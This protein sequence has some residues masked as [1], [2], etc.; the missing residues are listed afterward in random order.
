MATVVEKLHVNM[1]GAIESRKHNI[2]RHMSLE[3]SIP[4][5]PPGTGL[6]PI[7]PSTISHVSQTGNQKT[8]PN[9]D[10]RFLQ[11][12]WVNGGF[13]F[14]YGSKWYD[15]VLNKASVQADK[16]PICWRATCVSVLSKSFTSCQRVIS[17]AARRFWA[18]G[19][20]EILGPTKARIF[21]GVACLMSFVS[22]H[23]PARKK[24]ISHDLSTIFGSTGRLYSSAGAGCFASTRFSWMNLFL[25]YC[26]IHCGILFLLPSIF[27]C[28]FERLKD[29]FAAQFFFSSAMQQ[30]LVRASPT[31][32]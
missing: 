29:C 16:K 12:F 20:A 13:I 3:Y 15:A 14:L 19:V 23:G 31:L 4:N 9:F 11:L 21:S 8:G 1:W 17:P 28:S 7:P 18:S 26:T 5:M 24:N 2:C 6:A 25:L 27:W 30:N 32:H 22:S 10:A